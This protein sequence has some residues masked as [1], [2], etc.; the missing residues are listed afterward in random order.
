M[1]PLLLLLLSLLLLSL[2]LLLLFLPEMQLQD[3]LTSALLLLQLTAPRLVAVAR[4]QVVLEH[5]GRGIGD[6][7]CRHVFFSACRRRGC[8]SCTSTWSP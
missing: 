3:L 7:A 5:V 2:L 4:K 1:D 6:G 8:A